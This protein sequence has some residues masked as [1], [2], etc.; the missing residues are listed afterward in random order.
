MYKRS[1]IKNRGTVVAIAGQDFAFIASDRSSSSED[2]SNNPM[3]IFRLP[4]YTVLGVYGSQADTKAFVDAMQDCVCHYAVT[5]WR[6]LPLEHT[7][8]V[9]STLLAD[10]NRYCSAYTEVVLAGID[11][12]GR[13]AVYRKSYYSRLERV[14]ADIVGSSAEEMYR[15][16]MDLKDAREVASMNVAQM[17]EFVEELYSSSKEVDVACGGSCEMW[18]LSPGRHD[19]VYFE[20]VENKIRK[21]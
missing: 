18:I 2:V 6:H 15:R 9:L 19:D 1:L 13:G 4:N 8:N 10:S 16:G 11:D 17:T 3:K 5:H 14:A 7:A 21:K 12:T 20:V